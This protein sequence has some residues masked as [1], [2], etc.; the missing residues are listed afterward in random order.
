MVRKSLNLFC[1][2][3]F[4]LGLDLKAAG[5]MLLSHQETEVGRRGFLLRSL[6]PPM[7]ESFTVI[8]K[9]IHRI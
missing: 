4:C 2:L 8:E 1:N 3:Y 7:Q 5:D 9:V 6:I